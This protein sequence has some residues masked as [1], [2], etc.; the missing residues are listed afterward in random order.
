M[1]VLAPVP[2][3]GPEVHP[4]QEIR[5]DSPCTILPFKRQVPSTAE[6]PPTPGIPQDCPDAESLLGLVHRI[7]SLFERKWPLPANMEHDD[8]V[9]IGVIGLLKAI[10]RFDPARKCSIETYAGYAIRGA[11]FRHLTKTW[12]ALN[13]E[14]PLPDN[15]MEGPWPLPEKAVLYRELQD[16]VFTRLNDIDQT[17]VM[18]RLHEQTFAALG[19]Q[20]RMSVSKVCR[21]HR[22]A[23]RKLRTSLGGQGGGVS[24]PRK[25]QIPV[26]DHAFV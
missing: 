2:I 12:T 10:Q 26:P 25:E 24:K 15:E 9:A 20:L 3:P 13:H 5:R 16:A 6:S 7:A 22:R 1:S 17:L 18:G 14:A 4:Q 19:H 11:I 21:Q 8:V 23:L